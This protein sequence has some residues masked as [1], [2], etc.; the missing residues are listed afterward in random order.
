MS[1]EIDKVKAQLESKQAVVNELFHNIQDR[2]WEIKK[3]T[4][5]RRKL[6][7]QAEELQRRLKRLEGRLAD[8]QRDYFI[9]LEGMRL[10]TKAFHSAVDAMDEIDAQLEVGDPKSEIKKV[11][12]KFLADTLQARTTSAQDYARKAQEMLLMRI[13]KSGELSEEL[14]AE[15]GRL[16]EN[17]KEYMTDADTWAEIDEILSRSDR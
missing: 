16:M 5:E 9:L 13:W 12:E 15:L 6:Q 11:V 4:E 8:R 17:N 2:D 14:K 7:D 1:D 10:Y 3:L